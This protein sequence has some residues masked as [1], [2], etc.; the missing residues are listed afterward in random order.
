MPA[1]AGTKFR[2]SIS[3]TSSFSNISEISFV[4]LC[5]VINVLPCQQTDHWKYLIG[6]LRVYMVYLIRILND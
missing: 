4:K 1:F 6:L 5:V 2:S 3:C